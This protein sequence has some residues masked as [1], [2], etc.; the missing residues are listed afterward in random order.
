MFLPEPK[1]PKTK[2]IPVLAHYEPWGFQKLAAPRLQDSGS[3]ECRKVNP[4]FR[5]SLPPWNISGT[6]FFQRLSRIQ[7][8][9]A[10]GRIKTMTNSNESIEP[11]TFHFVAQCLGQVPHRH[12]LLSCVKKT[13]WYSAVRKCLWRDEYQ[14]SNTNCKFN[15]LNDRVSIT[16]KQ[17]DSN[18]PPTRYNNFPVYYPDVYLQLNMF[19]A[20]SC[21]S[22]GAQWLQWQPLVLP[23]YR[24]DSRAVFVVGPADRH[25]YLSVVIVVC[26]QLEVSATSWSLVQRSPTDCAASL[27]VI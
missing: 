3:H 26:C 25:G 8:H 1:N 4:T 17:N 12:C 15:K 9:S 7:R 16:N 23:S 10:A 6:Y 20:F 21:P 11:A 14:G 19:R 2:A 5:P 27:C 18:K 13:V 24:G 22:S